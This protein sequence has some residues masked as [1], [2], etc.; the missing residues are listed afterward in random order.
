[1]SYDPGWWK[2]AFQVAVFVFGVLIIVCTAG[3]WYF[4]RREEAAREALRAKQREEDRSR[5]TRMEAGINTLV[6]QGRLSRQDA[7]KLLQVVLSEQFTL[8][9]KVQLELRNA[10]PENTPKQP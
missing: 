4:G 2:A 9:D 10:Q 1:M 6:A 3:N 7:N 8:G 5:L